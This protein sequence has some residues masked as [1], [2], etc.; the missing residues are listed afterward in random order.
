MNN[1]QK[2]A[3]AG[4]AMRLLSAPD[5]EVLKTEVGR[6]IAPILQ[7]LQSFELDFGSG[8][9][10]SGPFVG[11]ARGSE[12]YIEI[13]SRRLRDVVGLHQGHPGETEEMNGMS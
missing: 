12:E 2:S 4:A 11:W 13:M 9:G 7:R 6:K 8:E 10:E 3:G 5:P 1:L